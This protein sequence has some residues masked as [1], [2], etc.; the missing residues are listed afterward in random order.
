VPDRTAG[1]K[2]RRDQHGFGNLRLRAPCSLRSLVVNLNAGG[3]PTPCFF[4]IAWDATLVMQE[5][6]TKRFVL[7]CMTDT[8]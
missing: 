6:Q 5:K 1:S 7:L 2:R 4:D 3:S 8:N